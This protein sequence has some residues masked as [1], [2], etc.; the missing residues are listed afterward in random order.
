MRPIR[1]YVHGALQPGADVPLPDASAAH[2][3]RVLRLGAG[4]EVVLFNGDGREYA[5]RLLAGDARRPQAR[6]E[7]VAAPARESPL[8]VTLLQAL[9]RGDK[10]DW[11]V[12]KA[13]ELGVARIAPVVTARSEVRLDGPR[14]ARRLE[15]WQAI[16][17]SACEQC[18]RNT[19]PVIDAP[20]ALASHAAA[21]GDSGPALRWMLCPGAATRLRDRRV[22]P[23]AAI[24]IAV[25]PE[26]G[27]DDDDLAALH[28]QGF[29][30]LALGPRVLRTETA[31]LA[32][33]AALQA[34]HGDF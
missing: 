30:A 29:E 34:L 19:L 22:P 13:T 24:E 14:A 31:G 33:L 1:L 21:R 20:G 26:G 3:L 2:A 7:A 25:G 18:G 9:A 32:A 23:N 28:A 17:I 16:A 4:D 10:M 8:R 12:Q 11:I 27:F 6:V 5:A 15:H